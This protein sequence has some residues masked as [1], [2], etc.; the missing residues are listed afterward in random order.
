MDDDW[1]YPHF[2]KPRNEPNCDVWKEGIKSWDHPEEGSWP[3][4][5]TMFSA[6]ARCN[7][8][9]E[10]T[11]TH[12]TLCLFP[13]VHM[14][15]VICKLHGFRL[16]MLQFHCMERW[17]LIP[18]RKENRVSKIIGFGPCDL[19]ASL[20]LFANF[21]SWKSCISFFVLFLHA[22]EKMYSRIWLFTNLYL[23]LGKVI[24]ICK[25]LH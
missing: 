21:P 19:Q 16:W 12:S 22:K 20:R 10:K 2:R 18:G 9:A 15:H 11:H 25:M 24:W 13:F 7:G 5:S 4:I 8:S 6:D 17:I 23:E 1:G 3:T 14:F